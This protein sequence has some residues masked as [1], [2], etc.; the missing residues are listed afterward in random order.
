MELSPKEN[1]HRNAIRHLSEVGID[2]E[3]IIRIQETLRQNDSQTRSIVTQVFYIP[4]G[5]SDKTV[6]EYTGSLSNF[7]NA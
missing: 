3:K 2:A 4:T 7:L 6:H 5:G 1:M